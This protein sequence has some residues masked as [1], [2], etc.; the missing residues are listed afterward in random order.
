MPNST[1][2]L[3]LKRSVQP[4][5][6]DLLPSENLSQW[7]YTKHIFSFFYPPI[8][9]LLNARRLP[10]LLTKSLIYAIE[11]SI[12]YNERKKRRANKMTFLLSQAERS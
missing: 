2:G 11:M 8:F 7:Q 6:I 4:F 10:N 9:L 5:P 1:L 12:F 3:Y